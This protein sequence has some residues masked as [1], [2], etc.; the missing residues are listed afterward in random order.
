MLK[1]LVALALLSSLLIPSVSYADGLLPLRPVSGNE[2]AGSLNSD[3]SLRGTSSNP[4]ATPIS[5]TVTTPISN[6]ASPYSSNPYASYNT[7]PTLQGTVTA[8]PKGQNLTIRLNEPVSSQTARIGDD[9]SATLE[10]PIVVN[11]Q[12]LVPAG[13]E[14]SGNV[15][16]VSEAG[17][18]GRHG[19]LGVKFYTVRTPNGETVSINGAIAASDED[20]VLK[21]DT[22]L[23]D[24]AKGAGIALLGTGLGAV[25]GTAVG[26]IVG[27][28]GSGAAIGTAI[29]AVAGIG[30]AAARQG[31]SVNLAKGTRL[32]VNLESDATLTGSPQTAYNPGNTFNY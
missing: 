1:Q 22:Y 31:K 15:T 3:L 10:A 19:E 30:Y 17:R 29:G 7:S 21:G 26:G 20:G 11:G 6:N 23:M 8:I 5:Q 2:S 14:V 18:L 25:G 13:S 24:I 27:A 16:S 28:A 32:D 4:Y 12:V 9:V